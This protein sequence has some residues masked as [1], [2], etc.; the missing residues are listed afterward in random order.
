MAHYNYVAMSCNMLCES[1]LSIKHSFHGIAFLRRDFHFGAI[2]Y[3]SLSHW[4]REGEIGCTVSAK[5][6]GE[7]IRMVKQSWGCDA[8]LLAFE[9]SKLVLHC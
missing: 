6:D 8:Y 7:S 2:H 4:Q 1:Y 9:C 5:V 3:Y